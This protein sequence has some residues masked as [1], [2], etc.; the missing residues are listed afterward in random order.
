[1]FMI[2]SYLVF[3]GQV[4][5]GL[6]RF[7]QWVVILPYDVLRRSPQ[8]F[9]HPGLWRL[10]SLL[11]VADDSTDSGVQLQRLRTRSGWDVPSADQSSNARRGSCQAC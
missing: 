11:V 2:Y 8:P 9:D 10:M 4:I 3:Q 6:W 5:P 1:M 7:G